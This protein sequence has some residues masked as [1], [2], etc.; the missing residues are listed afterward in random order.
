VRGGGRGLPRLRCHTSYPPPQP[1]PTLPTPT[2]PGRREHTETAAPTD[3]IHSKHSLAI[4]SQHDRA[5]VA[6]GSSVSP[7]SPVLVA[8]ERDATRSAVRRHA[9]TVV[10]GR[11]LQR[12]FQA[13]EAGAEAVRADRLVP[14]PP[15]RR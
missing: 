9:P 8:L 6:G 4:A 7:A 14:V 3:S 5:A 10:Q 11:P 13:G 15:Q 1:S 12:S 2:P